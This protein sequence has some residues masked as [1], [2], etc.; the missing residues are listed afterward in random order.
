MVVESE[1]ASST[2][3][4]DPFIKIL[5]AF[6]SAEKENQVIY[7]RLIHVLSRAGGDT[8][9]L[10]II[11]REIPG[12]T[13]GSVYLPPPGNERSEKNGIALLRDMAKFNYT[14]QSR[15]EPDQSAACRRNPSW[16]KLT[17]K[18]TAYITVWCWSYFSNF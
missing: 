9:S 3:D 15:K 1:E 16:I 6:Q 17:V 18:K 2:A 11:Y 13:N 7:W 10:C 12:E 14:S 8:T 5:A 4:N